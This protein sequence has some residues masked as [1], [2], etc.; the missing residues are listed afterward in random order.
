M[1][2][3]LAGYLDLPG[4]PQY[5]AAKFGVRGLM[6]ALRRTGPAMNLRVN[7][8]APW[9]IQTRIM[10]DQVVEVL[11]GKGIVFA[12]KADAAAAVLHLASDRSINGK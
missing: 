9:F 3:S 2:S 5:N 4:S 6:R 12:E 10:S 8:I 1:T 7:I 11:Q